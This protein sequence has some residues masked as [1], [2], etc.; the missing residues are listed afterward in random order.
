MRWECP[1]SRERRHQCLL[2][3]GRCEPGSDGCLLATLSDGNDTDADDVRRLAPDPPVE[4]AA[5]DE[6]ASR[7]VPTVKPRRRRTASRATSR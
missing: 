2:F 5:R 1:F 6:E 7:F 3:D 4:R